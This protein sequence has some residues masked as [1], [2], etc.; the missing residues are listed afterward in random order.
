MRRNRGKKRARVASF[1]G[2]TIDL[3]KKDL[4][5]NFADEKDETMG[6]GDT[7]KGKKANLTKTAACSFGISLRLTIGGWE[8]KGRKCRRR[9]TP[10]ARSK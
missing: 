3:G 10:A 2:G 1:E 7:C 5:K 6:S 8:K 9:K 4:D